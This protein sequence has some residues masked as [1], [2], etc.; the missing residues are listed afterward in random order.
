[1]QNRQLSFFKGSFAGAVGEVA[2]ILYG[3]YA[4]VAVHP[5]NQEQRPRNDTG[6]TQKNG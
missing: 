4:I 5:L 1:V 2:R 6:A 3:E